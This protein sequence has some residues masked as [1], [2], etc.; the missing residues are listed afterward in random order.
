MEAREPYTR[1][2]EGAGGALQAP[3]PRRGYEGR[4]GPWS[5]GG[6]EAEAT[7]SMWASPDG[8]RLRGGQRHSTTRRQQLG[9]GRWAPHLLRIPYTHTH[10]AV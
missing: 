5:G 7:S 8:R 3:R 9:F 2:E 10:P 6:V 4:R 1:T